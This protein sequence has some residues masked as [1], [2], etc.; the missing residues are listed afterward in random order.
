MGLHFVV[1]GVYPAGVGANNGILRSA[2]MNGDGMQDLVVGN[3]A[4]YFAVLLGK[5]DGTFQEAQRISPFALT[6]QSAIAD[7]NGDGKPD[8]VAT[9]SGQNVK[10]GVFVFLN[11][12]DGTLMDGVQT[13]GSTITTQG[14]AAI[15]IDGDMD[16]DIVASRGTSGI[17]VF[18]NGGD[19]TLTL[20]T[21]YS[22]AGSHSMFAVGAM[23]LDGDGVLDILATSTN[24]AKVLIF[25]KG[26]GDGT[27]ADATTIPAQRTDSMVIADFTG[28]MKPDVLLGAYSFSSPSA[29]LLVNNGDG[30][31]API[32]AQSALKT[33]LFGSGD[34]DGDGDTDVF[35]Y[36]SSAGLQYATSQ[37]NGTFDAPVFV[38]F[39]KNPRAAVAADFTGDGKV[40][41]AVGNDNPGLSVAPGDGMGSFLSP[42][43]TA[44]GSGAVHSVAADFDGDGRGDA[45][46]GH[47]SG[48]VTVLRGKAGGGLEPAGTYE[49]GDAPLRMFAFTADAN[50]SLDLVVTTRGNAEPPYLV[51]VLPNTGN[52]TF[53]APIASADEY[54]GPDSVA[55][56]DTD[57][58]GDLDI[59]SVADENNGGTSLKNN[60]DGT[61]SVNSYVY[62]DGA[63]LADFDEDGKLDVASAGDF[64]VYMAPGN[65]DGTFGNAKEYLLVDDIVSNLAAG[66][67]NGDGHADFVATFAQKDG[68]ALMLG[69][70]DGNF[71]GSSFATGLGISYDPVLED[72][73][74]DG[75]DDLILRAG[76]RV[77][78][79][80]WE[81]GF[82]TA[83]PSI[84]DV[85]GATSFS[86]ADVTGDG[87]P[88]LLVTSNPLNSLVVLRNVP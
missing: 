43:N 60:G 80:L 48:V 84:A 18:T 73:D 75:D 31:F 37:G 4:G 56:G 65:G 53:G 77:N 23:D 76:G 42:M 81:G 1:D 7:M 87:R 33:P 38:D 26:M 49:L 41:L 72:V 51:E 22:V 74:L 71:I 63:A 82:F 13:V 50:Q 83:G 36:S 34:V 59:L 3:S 8:V 2:D 61:F 69:L 9:R 21:T 62:M 19:G 20:S 85:Q 12:G 79:L 44:F 70:G 68:V 40:D 24:S 15:D 16:L 25:W 64:V 32:A 55:I 35:T 5:G 66:D 30:T 52:V 14:F 86:V 11:K 6:K 28:D 17:D 58:D 27:F 47:V 29:G 57:G 88:D 67:I 39:G 10:T 54:I 78:V 46:F 45:A